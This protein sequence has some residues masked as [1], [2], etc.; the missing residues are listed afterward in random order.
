MANLK[1]NAV[2]EN[3]IEIPCLSNAE[4]RECLNDIL[5]LAERDRAILGS[6]Y[7]YVGATTKIS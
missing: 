4:I 7:Y 6:Y 1:T 5:A 2:I 3:R